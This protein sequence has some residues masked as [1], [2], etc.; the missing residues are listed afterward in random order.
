MAA[1][2]EMA[3]AREAAAVPTVVATCLNDGRAATTRGAARER[4]ATRP[5]VALMLTVLNWVAAIFARI[6]SNKIDRV[7]LSL[8]M[9]EFV[10]S[11]V[12]NPPYLQ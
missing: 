2:A 9:E 3:K 8:L 5:W 7:Q 11:T 1:L 10:A 12:I 6:N 4:E